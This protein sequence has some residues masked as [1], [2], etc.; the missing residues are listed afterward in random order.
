[1]AL[2]PNHTFEELNEIK[3][4]IAEKNCSAERAEFLRKLL[5]KNGY[6]V[7]VAAAPPPKAAAPKPAAPLAEGEVAPPP[8]PPPPPA[9]SLFN[10]GVTNLAFSPTNMVFNRLL[11]TFDGKVVDMPYW[12]Q[13]STTADN[14]HWYWK[15]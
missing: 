5:E 8:P 13:E 10:V 14:D 9:P 3:C 11:K 7:V 15:E 1:M 12:K 4:A 6:T 2:N